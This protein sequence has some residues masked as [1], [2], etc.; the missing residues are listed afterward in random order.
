MFIHLVAIYVEVPRDI[1]QMRVDK[2]VQSKEFYSH[3]PNK[4]DCLTDHRASD[5]SRLKPMSNLGSLGRSVGGRRDRRRAVET[6]ENLRGNSR[7]PFI[8]T[9]AEKTESEDVREKRAGFL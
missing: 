6:R 8:M 4:T 7:T 2:F 9:A 5:W 3:E 1:I